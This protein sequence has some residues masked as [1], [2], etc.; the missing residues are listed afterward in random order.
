MAE[1]KL[2][3][4]N[5]RI[6]DIRSGTT[7]VKEVYKGID[8]I[9]EYVQH[10]LVLLNTSTAGTYTVNVPYD[11]TVHIDLVGGGGGGCYFDRHPQTIVFSYSCAGGSGAYVTGE[12]PITAGTYPVVVGAGGTGKYDS[13]AGNGGSSS[14]FGQTA[15]GGGGGK[16]DTVSGG[17][18]GVATTTLTGQNGNVG[19]RDIDKNS[20]S[21]SGG[22]SKYGGYGRGGNASGY[23]NLP[24]VENG[25]AGYCKIYIV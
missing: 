6:D 1:K 21:A 10:G 9:Y 15:G 2:Y 24:T 16:K 12:I 23:K 5:I 20:S 14:C 4:G 11:C 8:K 18:A 3:I 22:A 7:Q 13:N 19:G 17:T 25:V